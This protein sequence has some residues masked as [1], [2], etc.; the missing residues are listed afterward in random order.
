MRLNSEINPIVP[1][2]KPAIEATSTP[3]TTWLPTETTPIVN[4]KRSR[5]DSSN[6]KNWE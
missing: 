2:N 4:T 6:L 5:E 3:I 1:S